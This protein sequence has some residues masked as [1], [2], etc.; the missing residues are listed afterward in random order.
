MEMGQSSECRQ[1]S[2]DEKGCFDL[3]VVQMPLLVSWGNLIRQFHPGGSVVLVVF[4]LY[5]PM[6]RAP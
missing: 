3:F 2:V 5:H 6:R 4:E 1:S